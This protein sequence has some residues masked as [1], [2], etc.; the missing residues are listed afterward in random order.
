MSE[1]KDEPL[2]LVEHLEELRWRLIKCIIFFI[3]GTGFCFSLLDKILYFVTK[4]AKQL[5]FISPTEA[6]FSRLKLAF[7][8]GI[9]ISSPFI[10]FQVW[11]FIWVGLKKSERRYV[12][13]FGPSSFLLFFLGCAFG[14]LVVFPLAIKFF[15]G[16]A[17]EQIKP[18]LSLSRY[19]SFL[20]TLTLS[21]GVVFQLPLIL[22]FLTR[23]G[24]ATPYF[25][26]SKRKEAVVLIFIVSALI[27]PP[28]VITQII[29][30]L[31][32]II[33]YE[34]GIIFSKIAYKK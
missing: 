1:V 33:L 6:L 12:L 7:F 13:F 21:F 24:L 32:L 18:M 4:P 5:I 11:R 23:L 3:V 25:F 8:L 30:A 10:L 27:T 34:A 26:K 9:I 14:Y 31:P 28:D 19:L 22:S 2:T 20:T 16:F 29:M 15:L 17:T